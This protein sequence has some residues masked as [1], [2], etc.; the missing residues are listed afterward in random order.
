MTKP[1]II[2][3]PGAWHSPSHYESLL[4]KLREAGYLTKSEKLSSVG[5]SQPLDQT[6]ALDATA[7]KRDLLQPEL[8]LGKDVILVMHSYGG[9]PGAAAAKGN[10]KSERA[11]AG[12]QGGIIG[13][14][15]VCAFLANEGDSLKS[16][17]PGQELDP[18]CII[19]VG[20]VEMGF[21]NGR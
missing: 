16:K 9:S 14:I 5:S 8:D 3:V 1:T 10:S 20:L 4:V 21:A 7:I 18:W 15:F 2:L 6:A 19:D 13:L 12:K 17:L 11:A